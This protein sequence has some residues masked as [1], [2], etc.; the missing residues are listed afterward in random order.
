MFIKKKMRNGTFF[1]TNIHQQQQDQHQEYREN[2][3]A[4]GKVKID[5]IPEQQDRKGFEG[6]EYVDYEEVK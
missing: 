6:G 4:E 5:Y 2:G 1:H 3:K